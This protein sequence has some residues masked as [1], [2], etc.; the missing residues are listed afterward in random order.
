MWLVAGSGS[1][2]AA[3]GGLCVMFLTNHTALAP[4]DSTAT[5]PSN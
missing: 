5:H 3:P 4:R 1:E 2:V